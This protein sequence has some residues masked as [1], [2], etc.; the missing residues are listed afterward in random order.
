[1]HDPSRAAERAAWQQAGG[2]GR[3]GAARA[4]RELLRAG[5]MTSDE[6]MAALGVA[7]KKLIA[8]RIEPSVAAAIATVSRAFFAGRQVL[9]VEDI[10]RRVAELE[11]ADV[12][13]HR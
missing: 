3:S 6:M 1:M 13:L 5:A 12:E 2:K 7:A 4:R 10:E 8:G 11:R 9:L